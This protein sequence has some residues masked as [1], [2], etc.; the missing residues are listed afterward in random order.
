[1]RAAPR[2]TPADRLRALRDSQRRYAARGVTAVYEG[3]GIAP[4]V[5]AVYRESHA[6]GELRLRCT[7]AVS[8]TW[9]AGEAA[10]AIPDLAAWAGGR[11]LGDDRLRVGGICLHYGG[12]AGVAAHP[13]RLPAL[14]GVGRV[15][16]E[17]QRPR[18]L[19]RAGRAGGAPP[20]ARQHAGDALSAGGARRVGGG[21]AA[22]S[23][24]RP[25]LG[26]RPSQRGHAR[27]A[28]AHPPARR[29]RH[30]QPHLLSLPLGRR[31]GGQARRRRRP[32]PAPPEPGPPPHPVRDRHRQQAGRPLGRLRGG[33]RP[34]RHADGH[35]RGPSASGSP[36][37]RRS[38]PSRRAAPG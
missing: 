10:R 7:L 6:R 4:E 36:A 23:H 18:R 25:A 24:P 33:G 1:M 8:P 13:A 2:F 26:P 38:P 32:A 29:R 14:H 15:R 28:G 5:L 31:R 19:S 16:G 37:P 21:G 22:P 9:D 12:D 17:R 30:D 34:P 27:A 20:A 3:H 11:G 35:G